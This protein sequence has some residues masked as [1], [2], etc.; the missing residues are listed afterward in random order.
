[1]NRLTVFFVLGFVA[2]FVGVIVSRTSPVAFAA[3]QTVIITEAE[4]TRQPENSQ[5]TNHWVLYTR[6]AGNATF[7]TGPDTPPEGI[8]SLE[9]ITPTGA[10]KV[11]LFN[12]DHIGTRLSDIQGFSY[13]TYRTTGGSMGQVPA[14]NLEIDFNGPNVDGGFATLVFEPIYNTDQGVISDGIWQD[15]DGYSGGSATWWS[16]RAIPGVCA[17]NCFVSWS[18]IVSNNPDATILGGFGVNQGSG[19]PALTASADA[20][21]I[22]YGGTTTTY[23]FE[24]YKIATNKNQC[25]SDGWQTRKRANGTSFS[26]QGDCVSYTNTGN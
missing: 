2:L 5:P 17:F 11:T 7:R 3:D 18:S 6:N 1:M 26:N 24:P 15:W 21:S 23:D 12:Y 19:N 9:F 22:K 20:L 8:G 16:T 25:K 13:S 10:D 14:L 4:I